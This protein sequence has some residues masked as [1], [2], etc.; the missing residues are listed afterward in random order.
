MGVIEITVR[1]YHC[2]NSRDVS[3]KVEI[4]AV[5]SRI[6]MEQINTFC[7]QKFL[8]LNLVVHARATRL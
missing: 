6:E 7:R 4:T 2:F 8:M 5:C 3:Y 1:Y